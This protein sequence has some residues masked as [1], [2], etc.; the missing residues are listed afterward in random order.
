MSKA[1]KEVVKASKDD[2][3]VVT[4]RPDL[5]KFKMNELD[6]DTVSLLTKRAYDIAGCTKGVKVFLNGKRLPVS[7]L[8]VRGIYFY[9]YFRSR[10]FKIMFSF[11]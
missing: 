9:T 4:F 3:T 1:E 5:T 11:T 7:I 6:K 8:L 10:P 2:Y